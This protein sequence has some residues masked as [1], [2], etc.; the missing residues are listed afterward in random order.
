MWCGLRSRRWRVC[1]VA[2]LVM[3]AGLVCGV[4]VVARPAVAA[5]DDD[6]ASNGKTGVWPDHGD[7]VHGKGTW[8]DGWCKRGEHGYA[9]VVDHS[10][11]PP[12]R[13]GLLTAEHSG[14]FGPTAADGWIVRCHEGS[15]AKND[16]P[17]GLLYSVGILQQTRYHSPWDYDFPPGFT[18]VTSELS[19]D[20]FLGERR[21]WEGQPWRGRLH[22]WNNM[23]VIFPDPV[24]KDLPG[25]WPP[26]GTPIGGPWPS[27]D[28]NQILSVSESGQYYEGIPDGSVVYISYG[29]FGID[30]ENC[31]SPIG[32]V[33]DSAL[34]DEAFYVCLGSAAKNPQK[35][36]DKKTHQPCPGWTLTPQFSDGTVNGCVPRNPR[37]RPSV[38]TAGPTRDPGSGNGPHPRRPRHGH[39][40][41]PPARPHPDP[42]HDDSTGRGGSGSH[43]GGSTG[44]GHGAV[45][46]GNDAHKKDVRAG[47]RVSSQVRKAARTP[48]P[49][50]P[51]S[52]SATPSASASPSPSVSPSATPSPSVSAGV[53]VSPSP[54]DG[55]VWGSEQQGPAASDGARRRVPG[56]A[57]GAGAGVL[58]AAGVVAWWMTRGRRRD[59][60]DDEVGT[61]L[62]E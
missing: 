44:A 35:R 26:D 20:W 37:P 60:E 28:H 8:R 52:A 49:S 25:R 9:V 1:V 54:G 21:M 51:S 61:D 19:V 4:T 57:W 32:K 34:L 40:P 53:A 47:G 45:R 10:R 12:S 13:R 46:R 15:W 14:Q 48:S 30:Q 62:F 22:S 50:A 58:V 41:A 23:V 7:S 27:R 36:V 56:W 42:H 59:R 2:C 24:T 18:N 33:T 3:A 38:P 16:G 29:D 31:V 43:R 17:A 11:E 39:R 5:P 55:R 6:S